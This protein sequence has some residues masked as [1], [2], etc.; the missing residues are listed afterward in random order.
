M[1]AEQPLASRPA[2]GWSPA[3]L[4]VALFLAA[5]VGTAALIH[6]RLPIGGVPDVSGKLKALA[7][8]KEVNTVFIGSSLIRRQIDPAT[9]DQVLLARGHAVESFNAGID[10]M[11]FP[12]T[13]FYVDQ[14]L[15]GKPAGHLKWM[16]IEFVPVAPRIGEV[17]IN[18]PR[19][20]YWHDWKRT[21][22]SIERCLTG[23]RSW[24]QVSDAWVHVRLFTKKHFNLGRGT[25][26]FREWIDTPR[27]NPY[28]IQ[29]K[30]LGPKNDGF[31]PIDT[32]MPP[33]E[34]AQ[35]ERDLEKFR[36]IEASPDIEIGANRSRAEEILD[37]TRPSRTAPLDPVTKKMLP[38]L[39]ARIEAAGITPIFIIPPDTLLLGG[40]PEDGS[41]TLWDY[42][43]PAKYP[44]LYNPE[45]RYNSRHLN[46]QG[47]LIFTRLVAE[48]MAQFLEGR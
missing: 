12:E 15:H 26:L 40:L 18:T 42:A 6:L 1:T 44:D 34:V 19:P 47:A 13:E 11:L 28:R 29:G 5:L 35:F 31:L 16:V 2:P 21:V 37:I 32:R 46:R 25:E 9:F 48:R 36:R 38:S 45:S 30:I 39:K 33:A 8:R 3:W 17:Y 10:G 23:L 22:M 14:I 41:V 43:N 20:V 7:E 4:N 24:R 27:K